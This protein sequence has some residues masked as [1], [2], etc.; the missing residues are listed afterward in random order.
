M[1][2]LGL[3][4]ATCVAALLFAAAGD[5]VLGVDDVDG[6]GSEGQDLRSALLIVGAVLLIIFILVIIVLL[7]SLLVLRSPLAPWGNQFIGVAS[8]AA[9]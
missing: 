4:N 3:A 7:R 8:P 5:A 6:R 1:S 2:V 9:V